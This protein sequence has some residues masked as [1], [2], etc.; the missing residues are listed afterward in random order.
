[1]DT[2][3][4]AYLCLVIIMYST[5][6]QSTLLHY[7]NLIIKSNNLIQRWERLGGA[8]YPSRKPWPQATSG[9]M[10][11]WPWWSRSD[12]SFWWQ[13]RWRSV[14][15]PCHLPHLPC[16]LSPDPAT[17]QQEDLSA[18][19]IPSD[20]G[21]HPVQRNSM[22]QKFP[23]LPKKK[24]KKLWAWPWLLESTTS[25]TPKRRS[26]VTWASVFMSLCFSDILKP[27]QRNAVQQDFWRFPPFPD[28]IHLRMSD[29]TEQLCA[30]GGKAT[31]QQWRT[32]SH[33]NQRRCLC[34]C[35][36][37]LSFLTV[38]LSPSISPRRLLLCAFPA[39]LIGG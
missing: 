20:C 31:V 21:W 22:Q 24:K 6:L 4:L 32:V 23:L 29:I 7:D 28:I 9:C 11:S 37:R 10:I 5:Q 17:L 14:S 12:Q 15:S 8:T 26:S 35:F 25:W 3:D 19:G 2:G 13:G 30:R 36:S 1:M 18:R 16:F 33:I 39:A 34:P 27:W 38:F